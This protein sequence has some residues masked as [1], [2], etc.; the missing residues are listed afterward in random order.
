MRMLKNLNAKHWRIDQCQGTKMISWEHYADITDLMTEE[1]ERWLLWHFNHHG[2]LYS[3]YEDD[4]IV[5]RQQGELDH[6]TGTFI[7][8]YVIKQSNDIIK[9]INEGILK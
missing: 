7:P 3:H 4:T 6:T 8:N 2:W 1:N 9:K 5:F